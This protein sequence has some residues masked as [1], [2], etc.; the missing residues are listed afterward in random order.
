MPKKDGAD[1]V[2]QRPPNL[3]ILGASGHVAQAFLRG[4]WACAELGSLML[5]DRSEHVLK[6]LSFEH[7]RL[8]YTV[9]PPQAAVAGR[10][11]YVGSCCGVTR[12]TSCST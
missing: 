6:D 1:A 4:W 9:R 12:L 2:H 7:G 10:R 11:G 3:W 8:R 5:L